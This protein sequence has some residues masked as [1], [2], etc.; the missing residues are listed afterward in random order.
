[1]AVVFFNR[2]GS[3]NA[4]AS[5]AVGELAARGWFPRMVPT[6]SVVDVWSGRA[7]PKPVTT[8]HVSVP[9]DDSVCVTR[10]PAPPP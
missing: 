6:A 5:L 2:D 3:A 1:M 10:S 7:W 9:P 8:L 4:T